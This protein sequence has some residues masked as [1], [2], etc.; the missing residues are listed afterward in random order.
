ME[1][2]VLRKVSVENLCLLFIDSMSRLLKGKVKIPDDVKILSSDSI[3]SIS[4]KLGTVSVPSL[5]DFDVVVSEGFAS[6][7]V[8]LDGSKTIAATTKRIIDSALQSVSS[9][10]LIELRYAGVGFR[11]EKKGD[12][13]LLSIGKSHSVYV[14]IPNGIDVSFPSQ[15]VIAISGFSKQAVGQFAS[16]VKRVK[17]VEPYKGK[18]IW[19]TGDFIIRKDAK[20]GKK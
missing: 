13:L 5:N 20:A 10:F 1:K 3:V 7:N 6:V 15:G 9:G 19:K 2:S 4:G 14:L 12:G 18:G 11:A 17:K 8:G 16:S